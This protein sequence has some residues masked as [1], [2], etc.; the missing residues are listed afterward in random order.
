MKTN[1]ISRRK[2]WF[3][4]LASDVAQHRWTCCPEILFRVLHG[5]P[6]AETL[7]FTAA[8]ME[9]YLSAFEARWPDV[10]WPREII[11]SPADWV[12]RFRRALPDEPDFALIS[13]AKFKF[14]LDALLLGCQHSEDPGILA[15]SCARAV[16]E[17]MGALVQERLG[18][19]TTL[20]DTLGCGKCGGQAK[21]PALLDPDSP[22]E[23]ARGVA[24]QIVVDRLMMLHLDA[25]PDTPTEVLDR[26]LARWQ[27]HEM[28]LIVPESSFLFPAATIL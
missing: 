14:S 27:R 19:E 11:A 25:Y 13:D 5:L 1:T 4:E 17:A 3:V 8:V 7:S 12:R 22:P 20:S 6:V 24:W 18:P 26:D 28:L 15:S 2:G 9:K 16:L 21:P 10:K 23:V